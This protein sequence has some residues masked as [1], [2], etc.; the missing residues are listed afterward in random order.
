MAIEEQTSDIAQ[1]VHLNKS[2]EETG[3]GDQVVIAMHTVI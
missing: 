1:A 2:D 3:A